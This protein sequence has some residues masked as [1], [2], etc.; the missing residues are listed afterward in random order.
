MNYV[1]YLG[2]EPTETAIILE[3]GVNLYRRHSG[4]RLEY[5][6]IPTYL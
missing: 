4:M 6:L 5:K 2:R 3:V 1:Q